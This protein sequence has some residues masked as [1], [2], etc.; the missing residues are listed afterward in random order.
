MLPLFP[1]RSKTHQ[2]LKKFVKKV[3]E[4]VIT[5]KRKVLSQGKGAS[6]VNDHE[7]DLL[8]LMIEAGEDGY[9]ALSDYD[10]RVCSIRS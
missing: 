1:A 4:I 5:E 7:K 10:L 2:E 8:T 6:K 9:G 3:D